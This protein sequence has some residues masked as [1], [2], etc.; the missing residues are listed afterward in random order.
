MS[1]FPIRFSINERQA[2]FPVQQREL[3]LTAQ[4]LKN[5]YPL[6]IYLNIVESGNRIGVKH[7]LSIADCL[8]KR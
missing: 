4:V 3:M 8:W 7:Q 6:E 5:M 1:V 2:S